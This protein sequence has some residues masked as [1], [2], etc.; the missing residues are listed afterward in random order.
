MAGFEQAVPRDWWEVLALNG[1]MKMEKTEGE[2]FFLKWET[3]S[4]SGSFYTSCSPVLFLP[5]Q[6]MEKIVN[7][8]FCAIGGIL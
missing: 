6:S 1:T 8:V 4:S 3:D 7:Q 2:F 5:C